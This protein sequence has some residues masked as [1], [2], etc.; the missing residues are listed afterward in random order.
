MTKSGNKTVIVIVIVN[1][2]RLLLVW[3]RRL[4]NPM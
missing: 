1:G 3:S 4:L 2:E